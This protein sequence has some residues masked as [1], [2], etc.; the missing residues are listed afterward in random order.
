[1][2]TRGSGREALV[3]AVVAQMRS[4]SWLRKAFG[5]TRADVVSNAVVANNTWDYHFGPGKTDIRVAVAE[6]LREHT[7]TEAA[8][9]A[10]EYESFLTTLTRMSPGQDLRSL[11]RGAVRDALA[12]DLSDFGSSDRIYY[13]LVSLADASPDIAQHLKAAHEV[14]QSGFDNVYDGFLELTGRAYLTPHEH[15]L[16]RRAIGTYLE[17]VQTLARFDAGPRHEG[18]LDIDEITDVVLRLFWATTRKYGQDAVDIDDDLFGTRPAHL[19]DPQLTGPADN[20]AL[21]ATRGSQDSYAVAIRALAAAADE[22]VEGTICHASLHGHRTAGDRPAGT[23]AETLKSR[24]RDMVTSGWHLKRLVRVADLKHLNQELADAK[25][26]ASAGRKGGQGGGIEV[27]AVAGDLLPALMPLIAGDR[28]A[29]LGVDNANTHRPH[30][31]LAI[32]GVE[33]IRV[34]QQHF[35]AI[36]DDRRCYRIWDAEGQVDDGVSS[37]KTTLSARCRPD[38]E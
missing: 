14:S 18:G 1:M 12:R 30:S 26:F 28:H 6:H 32:T 22:E 37:L 17:G 15:N 13:A 36:W 29:V 7:I 25:A 24:Q 21:N 23:G 19:P 33:P 5:L 16:T 38:T 2:A 20:P 27:R 3:S 9:N 10:G 35:Q 11:G 34:L 8:K 4:P 31:V